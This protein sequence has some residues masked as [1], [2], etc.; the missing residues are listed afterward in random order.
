MP[1]I[2]RLRRSLLAPSVDADPRFDTINY[3]DISG[4]VISSDSDSDVSSVYFPTLPSVPEWELEVEE[5]A[6]SEPEL[7]HAVRAD[8]L[9]PWLS[10]PSTLLQEDVSDVYSYGGKVS[11]TKTTKRSSA[12][13]I[14][15]PVCGISTH[16]PF[17]G[18]TSRSTYFRRRAATAAA[19]ASSQ[20]KLSISFD[21][22]LT[23]LQT[24]DPFQPQE[25]QRLY[26]LQGLVDDQ[27]RF[28]LSLSAL[29]ST[30]NPKAAESL[31]PSSTTIDKYLKELLYSDYRAEKSISQSLDPLIVYTMTGIGGANPPPPPP[32]SHPPGPPGKVSDCKGVEKGKRRK[33][34]HDD[35]NDDEI[36]DATERGNCCA[37]LDGIP[38]W[39]LDAQQLFLGQWAQEAQGRAIQQTLLQPEPQQQHQEPQQDQPQPQQAVSN[40]DLREMLPEGSLEDKMKF[41]RQRRLNGVRRS[42][43]SAACLPTSTPQTSHPASLPAL[44]F[45]QQELSSITTDELVSTTDELV[46]TTEDES[47]STAGNDGSVSAPV[48]S[49]TSSASLARLPRSKES[50]ASGGEGGGGG[51][52]GGGRGGNVKIGRNTNLTRDRIYL[53]PNRA[54]SDSY[55]RAFNSTL[56]PSTSTLPPSFNPG[57]M[58][59]IPFY[60]GQ[61][62]V[63]SSPPVYT[64]DSFNFG[65]T[66]AIR[67][68]FGQDVR[69]SSPSSASDS[70]RASS[71]ATNSD[72]S[73]TPFIFGAS[74]AGST[75]ES[76]P[77]SASRRASFPASTH[78]PFNFTPSTNSILTP[79]TN[80]IP[81]NFTANTGSTASSFQRPPSSGA[82]ASS[83]ATPFIFIP[84]TLTRFAAASGPAISFGTGGPIESLSTPSSPFA[85]TTFPVVPGDELLSATPFNYA[86]VFCSSPSQENDKT[87]AVDS[88][89]ATTGSGVAVDQ[90]ASTAA[91]GSA[92]PINYRVSVS[93][94]PF[95]AATPL[96]PGPS[97]SDVVSSAAQP[98]TL[99]TEDTTNAATSPTVSD[100]GAS[101]SLIDLDFTSLTFSDIPP[102]QPTSSGTGDVALSSSTVFN[103]PPVSSPTVSDGGTL[104]S[105]TSIGSSTGSDISGGQPV[106]FEAGVTI[107]GSSSVSSSSR[108]TSITSSS[109]KCPNRPSAYKSANAGANHVNSRYSTGPAKIAPT[110]KPVRKPPSLHSRSLGS[111]HSDDDE[112]SSSSYSDDGNGDQSA[113]EPASTPN[114][115][116]S[117][118]IL[119]VSSSALPPVTAL[120]PSST[121]YYSTIALSLSNV[122]PPTTASGSSQSPGPPA[123]TDILDNLLAAITSQ[124]LAIRD[125]ESSVLP[126]APTSHRGP[127]QAVLS[128]ASMLTQAASSSSSTEIPA[129]GAPTA[130]LTHLSLLAQAAAIGLPVSPTSSGAAASVSAGSNLMIQSADTCQSVSTSNV[131]LADGIEGSASPSSGGGLLSEGG[132]E[133]LSSESEA[134]GQPGGSP[135]SSGSDSDSDSDSESNPPSSL[136]PYEAL[137]EA[138]MNWSV[139]CTSAASPLG[140]VQPLPPASGSPDTSLSEPLITNAPQIGNLAVLVPSST[141]LASLSASSQPTISGAG[142]G[143]SDNLQ[144]IPELTFVKQVTPGASI[145]PISATVTTLVSTAYDAS[146]STA[147]A[148]AGLSSSNP[149]S[150][151]T[152]ASSTGHS[153]Q[154]VIAPILSA[155]SGSSGVPASAGSSASSGSTTTATTTTTT[156]TS[157]SATTTPIISAIAA[158][159]TPIT[160]ISVSTAGPGHVGAR[161]PGGGIAPVGASA[162]SSST[163]QSSSTA[164]SINLRRHAR[165]GESDMDIDDDNRH[166][167]K[168][169]LISF[170]SV[171]T[172]P[173]TTIVPTTASV[174]V[175]S[176]A[177]ASTSGSNRPWWVTFAPGSGIRVNQPPVVPAPVPLVP[178]IWSSSSSGS[179]SSSSQQQ[180]S[181]QSLSLFPQQT[182]Q[183]QSPPAKAAQSTHSACMQQ[184][185]QVHS[186]V[187]QQNQP[188]QSAF[189]QQNPLGQDFLRILRHWQC[190]LLYGLLDIQPSSEAPHPNLQDLQHL[191]KLPPGSHP[192]KSQRG[193]HQNHRHPS[194]L[195]DPDRHHY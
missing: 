155:S 44:L 108:H 110:Q 139:S 30:H 188:I 63:V 189:A 85:P 172:T 167:N 134:P 171:A 165:D 9:V 11:T 138:M 112:S 157:T 163:G 159:I 182:Q 176:A 125:V 192:P 186:G 26:E 102:E 88:A 109:Q 37:V 31:S 113:P 75:A 120:R 24:L 79:S 101:P 129:R 180:M 161:Q 190:N 115:L 152:I 10:P 140:S 111:Q 191:A 13:R 126:A 71:P 166:Q 99:E 6:E 47:M 58:T 142:G 185:Q 83:P 118:A 80:S 128:N 78:I 127:P 3:R 114:L 131:A 84:S 87:D 52:G 62:P 57:S 8:V 91:S 21:E 149:L 17:R 164:P 94:I 69:S 22:Y 177:P 43:A 187:I 148:A 183:T 1:L 121:Y 169:P 53:V 137:V 100:G 104:L 29:T 105:S 82:S 65:S 193:P 146:A 93:A 70:R 67:A 45:V 153:A 156:A 5:D 119:P 34:I 42:V 49:S 60:N 64:S 39:G 86:E 162:S 19:S 23:L 81:F 73:P 90:S 181:M 61:G 195:L 40:R 168:R 18:L 98:V 55:L 32:P 179:L 107:D 25:I 116:G 77:S 175:S 66:S 35:D 46:S 56:D 144:P 170:G 151:M 123:T 133:G 15:R 106:A 95:V 14:S 72:G 194:D 20:T 48:G 59:A 130:I 38:E 143:N 16:L 158:V 97:T 117:Y 76:S 124:G 68:P 92:V 12:T 33:Q 103:S 154:G 160:T 4:R 132:G 135:G 173:A 145:T 36:A 41:L 96:G 51:G 89:A 178:P 50:G 122:A 7:T 54:E 174:S 136:N 184:M 2:Q 147:A 74:V 150:Q 28:P 141:E 27:S